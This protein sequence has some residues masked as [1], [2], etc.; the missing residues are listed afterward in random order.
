MAE[1]IYPEYRA[2]SLRPV[3]PNRAAE[4]KWHH[5]AVLAARFLLLLVIVLTPWLFGG[6]QAVVQLGICGIVLAAL[7]CWLIALYTGGQTRIFVPIASIPLLC[8]IIFGLMQLIPLKPSVL[9][10]LAPTAARHWEPIAGE[11]APTVDGPLF[12]AP[13]TV[14][15][16]PASTRHDAALLALATTVFLLGAHFFASRKAQVW[17]WA[18]VALNGAALTVFGIVQQLTWNGRLYWSIEPTQVTKAFGP[19]VNHNNAAGYLSMCL[20]GAIGLLLLSPARNRASGGRNGRGSTGSTAVDSLRSSA[21]VRLAAMLLTGT[22]AAGIA[23]SLSRG[24]FVST[25]GAAIVTVL[26]MFFV[27]R[28]FKQ[29]WLIGA[30]VLLA[31]LLVGWLGMS[32][33]VQTRMASL[34]DQRANPDERL[35]HWQETLTAV[36]DFWLT[37][38]GLGTYRYIYRYYEKRLGE[39]WF[40]HAENQYLEALV[41]GGILGIGLLIAAIALIAAA[42]LHVARS[43]R[44]GSGQAFALAAVFAVTT[45]LIHGFFDFGLYLPANMLLFA[46]ICGAVVGRA[47]RWPGSPYRLASFVELRSLRVTA[48]VVVSLIV[49]CVYPLVEI[50][51]IAALDSARAKLDALTENASLQARELAIIEF[52]NAVR[53]RRDDAEAQSTLARMWIEQYRRRAYEDVKQSDSSRSEAELRRLTDVSMLRRRA[54]E[55]IK[56]GDTDGLERLRQAPIVRN[57]LRPA[58]EHMFLARRSCPIMP[59]VHL[60][61]AELCFLVQDPSAETRYL[62]P[63]ADLAPHRPDLAYRAG[64]LH[65]GSERNDLAFQSWRA[66]LSRSSR[67]ADDILSLSRKRADM[68]TVIEKV[69][70][71]L[72]EL[73][74][75][76]AQ[77]QFPA[78]ESLETH[79]LLLDAAEHAL[80]QNDPFEPETLYLHGLL[81]AMQDEPAKA[82]KYY[83]QALAVH[84]DRHRWRYEFAILLEQRGQLQEALVEVR[85]CLLKEPQNATYREMV[86]Q[87]TLARLR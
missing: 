34:L 31:A 70:P 14:S 72:P 80:Q 59:H 58:F 18:T 43:E 20:A 48:L 30:A 78:S 76:L 81:S 74:L 21:A 19:Y 67:F 15:L 46:L 73:L 9:R 2:E 63:L 50:G 13:A 10:Q 82:V 25:V 6:V 65:Y 22:I 17:L 35:V 12:D 44:S 61:L 57:H 87:I 66:S 49:Q 83:R 47:R 24:A 86:R 29:A 16:Y 71:E 54:Y 23:C 51:S 26:T 27:Q 36:P 52:G 79:H 56:A 37:G 55:L 69:I 60:K 85:R 53:K 40:Y 77:R 39:E 41:E 32:D 11:T 84:P 62:K 64:L 45:Q 42:A 3:S 7:V 75:H 68:P 38:S 4:S 28:N 8:G 5:R 33:T 1:T